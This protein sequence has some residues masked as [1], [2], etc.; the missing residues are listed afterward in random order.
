[1]IFVEVASRFLHNFRVA[2]RRE[3]G[4]SM[5]S[6]DSWT[7]REKGE[8]ENSQK[9]GKDRARQEVKEKDVLPIEKGT[10]STLKDVLPHFVI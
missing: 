1:M 6:G 5:N 3:N 9:Q 4:K 10:F 2:L 8:A 7:Q